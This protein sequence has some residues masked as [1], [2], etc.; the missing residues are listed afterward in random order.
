MSASSRVLATGE[1]GGVRRSTKSKNE[2]EFENNAGSSNFETSAF[3]VQAPSWST[4]STLL[5]PAS[6][7]DSA[8]AWKNTAHSAP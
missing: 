5:Q 3:A 1:S 4:S 2:S 7:T 6:S 8:S